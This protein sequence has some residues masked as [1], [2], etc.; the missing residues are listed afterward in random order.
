MAE[1]D[2]NNHSSCEKKQARP[3]R[4]KEL[5]WDKGVSAVFRDKES[6]QGLGNSTPD[7]GK[8][9]GTTRSLRS[10]L[11]VEPKGHMLRRNSRE[12]AGLEK[13]EGDFPS[14]KK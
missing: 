4:N 7:T 3:Q 6:A 13:L 1:R 5:K 2:Y 8:S 14:G 11:L 9:L 12:S 10:F